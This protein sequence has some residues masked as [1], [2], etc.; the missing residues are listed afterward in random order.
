[1]E[2]KIGVVDNARELS[3]TTSEPADTIESHVADVLR[4][5]DGVLSLADD[6]GRRYLVPTT[7]LAYVEIGPSEASKVGFSAP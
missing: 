7:K 2:V 1:M 4:Q 3:M 5:A 6:K